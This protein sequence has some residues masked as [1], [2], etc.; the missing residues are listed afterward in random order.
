MKGCKTVAGLFLL[1]V[2]GT[3]A[4]WRIAPALPD[5]TGQSAL[6]QEVERAGQLQRQLDE[7]N[8]RSEIKERI[9]KQFLTGD[10]TLLEAAASFRNVNRQS[11]DF[12]I[13]S[14]ALLPGRTEEEKTCNQVLFW[15]A[16]VLSAH[17]DQD[18]DEIIAELREEL[19]AHI[20]ESGAPL[21]PAVGVQVAPGMAPPGSHLAV[22]H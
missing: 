14:A 9:T 22:P 16:A 15:V 3:C 6:D 13:G 5:G 11:A 19:E 1:L 2:L 18:A 12:P 20:R 4:A 10:I 21:L 8:R 17:E 7:L